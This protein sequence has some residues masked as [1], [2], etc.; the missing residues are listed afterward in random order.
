MSSDDSSDIVNQNVVNPVFFTDESG[1]ILCILLAVPV[2]NHDNLI[3]PAFHLFFHDIHDPV[4][5]FFASTLFSNDTELSFII[6]VDHRLDL[7]H[8][9]EDRSGF[10]NPTATV[11]VVQVVNRDIVANMKFIL[12]RPCYD[13]VIA[14]SLFLKL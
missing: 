11:Q 10:G 7:Y 9:A 5:G 6:H 4:E 13:L 8:C 14:L 12:L 1:D 3:V 2:S